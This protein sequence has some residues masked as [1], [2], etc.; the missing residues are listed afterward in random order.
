MIKTNKHRKGLIM[1]A[2]N[3]LTIKQETTKLL[4]QYEKNDSDNKIGT[5]KISLICQI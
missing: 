4:L 2:I 5:N 1:K 3:K